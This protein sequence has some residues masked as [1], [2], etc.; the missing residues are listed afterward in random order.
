MAFSMFPSMI[1]QDW[2]PSWNFCFM[3]SWYNCRTTSKMVL[4]Y[5]TRYTKLLFRDNRQ[6]LKARKPKHMQ[7]KDLWTLAAPRIKV[8]CPLPPPFTNQK[9][10]THLEF[11]QPFQKPRVHC[12]GRSCVNPLHHKWPGS[13][14]LQLKL[15]PPALH[16]PAFPSLLK[17]P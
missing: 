17:N 12:P 1:L 5:L 6:K 11:E 10:E 15:V 16:I 3:G 8:F 4:F 13:K 7:R 14:V 2:F 9:I